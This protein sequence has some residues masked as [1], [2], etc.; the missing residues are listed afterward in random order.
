MELMVER[1]MLVGIHALSIGGLQASPSTG[2]HSSRTTTKKRSKHRDDMANA[3]QI[4]SVLP[5]YIPPLAGAVTRDSIPRE[6]EY[7]LITAYISKG[8]HV[9]GPQLGH[10]LALKNNGFN[11][12]DMKNY[13]MLAPH[14][15]L[16]KTTG[17]KL[18]IVSQPWINELA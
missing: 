12:G 16:M 3:K 10:I 18:R 9:I 5:E 17:K 6:F 11:L 2:R 7:T 14:R 4:L 1:V 15:Y 13:V 8:I